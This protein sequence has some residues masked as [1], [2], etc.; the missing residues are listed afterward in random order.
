[1]GP[2]GQILLEKRN[3]QILHSFWYKL[4]GE[5]ERRKYMLLTYTGMRKLVLEVLNIC[6]VS[7]KIILDKHILLVLN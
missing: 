4:P 1:M 3:M 5:I 6:V 2:K 7:Q